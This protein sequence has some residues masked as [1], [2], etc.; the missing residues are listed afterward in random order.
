M[1]L[2]L[3]FASVVLV[4]HPVEFV[5]LPGVCGSTNV[6]QRW[7]SSI[8]AE[9]YRLEVSP[10]N[11]VVA[12]SDAAGAFYARQTLVQLAEA[13][14]GKTVYPCCRI[15]DRPAYPWRGVMMT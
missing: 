4:P 9:G 14:D 10:S 13:R 7:D 5:E 1:N 2:L 11:V 8:A 6:T 15:N 12:S 3:L